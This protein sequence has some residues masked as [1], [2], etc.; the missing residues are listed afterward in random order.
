MNL[1]GFGGPQRAQMGAPMQPRNP[2]YNQIA[3]QMAPRVSAPLTAPAAQPQRPPTPA[4]MIG[5]QRTPM[6]GT[7]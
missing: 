3:M 1:Y 5:L 6:R 7:Y 2:I 4:G